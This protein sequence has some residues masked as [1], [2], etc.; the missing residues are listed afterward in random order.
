MPR[1]FF[2]LAYNGTNFSGWQRQENT[3][4]TIQAHVEEKLSLL[5]GQ[6][7][8]IIGCGRTD[9]G[10]HAR[11]FYFHMDHGALDIDRLKYKLNR[12]MSER[13]VLKRIFEVD[14]SAH[15]RFSAESRKY[16]FY[17]STKPMVFDRAFK[18]QVEGP[19]HFRRIEE[20][21]AV[22]KGVHDFRAFCKSPDRHRSTLCRVMENTF[23]ER[24]SEHEFYISIEANRFLKSMMRIL[25]Y[26]LLQLAQGQLSLDRFKEMIEEGSTG[27]TIKMLPPQGLFLMQV[28]YPDA[29]LKV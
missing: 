1:Y 19:L 11:S 5:L 21:L 25:V 27:E 14:P 2:E 4:N 12:L 15:A 13:V 3:S 23:V 29:V 6:K 24:I 16:H 22:I 20:G 7:V 8:S 26:R 10:V 28:N 17:F 9:K 18:V